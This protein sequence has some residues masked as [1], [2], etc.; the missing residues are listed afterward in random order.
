MSVA[1]RTDPVEAI[2]LYC[3]LYFTLL[4]CIV[5]VPDPPVEVELTE[6]LS[7]FAQIQWKLI[8]ENYSPVEEFI[9]EYNTS[10]DPGRW[11]VAKGQLP[12]D[13]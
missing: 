4:F 9:I 11:T 13:R 10:F 5:A 8:S 12:R 1:V 6:C 7:R 2:V 3:S